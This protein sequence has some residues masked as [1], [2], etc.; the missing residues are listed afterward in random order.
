V[1]DEEI[2]A[3]IEYVTGGITE[4]VY[5]MK[6][7]GESDL[8]DAARSI[9]FKANLPLAEQDLNLL[10][11]GIP[12]NCSL[13]LCYKPVSDLAADELQTLREYLRAGGNFLLLTRRRS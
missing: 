4:N 6:G 9:L 2:T 11:T 12:R 8:P 13:I 1:T 10:R 3:A 5:L 7:H